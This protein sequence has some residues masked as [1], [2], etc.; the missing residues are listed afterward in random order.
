MG[1]GLRKG[2]ERRVSDRQRDAADERLK[3]EKASRKEGT[4]VY[5]REPDASFADLRLNRGRIGDFFA[6]DLLKLRIHLSYQGFLTLESDYMCTDR[7][8]ETCR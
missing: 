3:V 8:P 6:L 7:Y 1:R 5:D 2:E 4:V